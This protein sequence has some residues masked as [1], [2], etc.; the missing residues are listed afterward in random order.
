M[1]LILTLDKV[2][3]IKS[4]TCAPP[5]GQSFEYSVT[6]GSK[7][8]CVLVFRIT[9]FVFVRV[10]V[11]RMDAVNY[12]RGALL[13]TDAFTQHHLMYPLVWS[14]SIQ[15]TLQLLTCVQYRRNSG[16]RFDFKL[17]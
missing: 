11:G 2:L 4:D 13:H 5:A 6:I 14:R 3:S 8:Y 16:L 1:A 10:T 7:Q 15:L 9:Q 12:L 17:L